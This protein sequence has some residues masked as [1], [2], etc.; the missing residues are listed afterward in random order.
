MEKMN[1]D[2]ELF[3]E[4]LCADP[5]EPKPYIVSYYDDGHHVEV[6]YSDGSIS[7]WGKDI[8]EELMRLLVTEIEDDSK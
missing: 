1:K 4:E 6:E 3:W 5:P 8:E 7:A 2:K